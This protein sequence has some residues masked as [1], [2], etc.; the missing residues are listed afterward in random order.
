VQRNRY[1]EQIRRPR[2]YAKPTADIIDQPLEAEI[3]QR[4]KRTA[5]ASLRHSANSR[6]AQPAAQIAVDAAVDELIII[7]RDRR[8]V[9]FVAGELADH[10]A[11]LRLLPSA[12]APDSR[13]SARTSYWV[14]E[15][16]PTIVNVGVAARSTVQEV[17]ANALR[18]LGQ[19]AGAAPSGE[20]YGELGLQAQLALETR[21]VQQAIGMIFNNQAAV[22]RARALL[23][24]I[25]DAKLQGALEAES[26]RQKYALRAWGA[27]SALSE[28]DERLLQGQ[29]MHQD[30]RVGALYQRLSAA[31]ADQLAAD[32]SPDGLLHE[33]VI[34]VKGVDAS[35][36]AAPKPVALAPAPTQVAQQEP[37]KLDTRH[38]PTGKQQAILEIM[39]DRPDMAVTYQWMHERLIAQGY[40]IAR[41]DH[42]RIILRRMSARGYLQQLPNC[43]F[44]LA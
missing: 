35:R 27:F 22:G 33:L 43:R 9:L 2:G 44:K 32:V 13:W 31:A 29:L 4:A 41:P 19:L 28:T 3:T 7:L 34:A 36:P 25:S 8:E 26:G 24:Q 42:V 1:D 38:D 39:A 11:G 15:D 40:E 5:K 18:A 14:W 10:G 12:M 6:P 23:R 30:A 17:V 20:N 16:E 37:T 21:F